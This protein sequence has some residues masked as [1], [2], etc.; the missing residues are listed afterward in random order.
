M[1]I[2]LHHFSNLWG[3]DPSPY[4][5]KVQTYLRLTGVEYI[6]KTGLN[7]IKNAPRKQLP[8]IDD[9]GTIV[10]DS[11]KIID[12]L[13]EKYGNRLDEELSTEQKAIG[14]AVSRMLEEGYYWIGVYMRW[15]DSDETWKAY[16][17][18]LFGSF[19]RPIRNF[20]GNSVKRDYRKRVRGQ[21]VGRY[22]STELK[23]MGD[24]DTS[25]ISTILGEKAFL[26]SD[27]ISSYDATVF[28]FLG[29]NFYA[30]L[31]THLKKSIASHPNIVRYIERISQIVRLPEK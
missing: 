10:A 15:F 13:K 28:G 27:K 8:Y 14:H 3:I 26:L 18:A 5:L 21:G 12:H 29:N 24:T 31:D 17:P 30:P 6:S 19:P 11:H 4:C 25:C 23:E 7:S 22:T 1:T 2:E 9:A 16:E 20:V